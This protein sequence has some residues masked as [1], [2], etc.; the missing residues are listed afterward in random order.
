[1]PKRTFLLDKKKVLISIKN[2]P[3]RFSLDDFV[4][5]MTLLENIERGIA[6]S[7]AGR[8]VSLAEAKLRMTK[9]L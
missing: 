6:D 8:T 3:E 4:D 5:H 2:L 7:E 1:M 9:W